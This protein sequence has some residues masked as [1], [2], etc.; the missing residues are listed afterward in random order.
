MPLVEAPRPT[1]NS[2]VAASPH[3]P[4]RLER[5]I[6]ATLLVAL[7]IGCFVVLRPFVAAILWGAILAYATWPVFGMVQRRL[8]IGRSAASLLMI[9]AAFLVMLAPLFLVVADVA[10]GAKQLAKAGRDIL[11]AGLPGPPDWIAAIPL[12]GSRVDDQWRSLSTQEQE[13]QGLLAPYAAAMGR[14]GLDKG[15]NVG[16]VLAQGAL[17]LALALFVAFFFYRD[18]EAL[19]GRARDGLSRLLGERGPRLLAVAGNTV[20]S[21]VYGVLGTALVQATLMLVGLLVAGVP[22]AV[23]LAFVTGVTSPLPIGPPVV[24]LGAA[25]WLYATAGWGWAVFML[26]WGAGLVSMADNVVRPLL[27]SRG[28][29]TPIVVTLLGILGGVIAFGF[30]GLFIGPTLLAVGYSLVHEWTTRHL[31]ADAQ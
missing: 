30:L 11:A 21:V 17:E 16:I 13:I 25:A 6:A 19:A 26:A 12:V 7:A 14:W 31:A 27:I 29:T 18:G 1:H 15:V 5:G 20:K 4:S 8:G 28:G 24:W 2:P 22:N 23:L 9:V 10:D 3:P